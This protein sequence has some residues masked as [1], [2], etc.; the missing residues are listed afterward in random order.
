VAN[1][2]ERLGTRK[3][4]ETAGMGH[5]TLSLLSEPEAA[6]IYSIKIQGTGSIKVGN[7]IVVCDAGGG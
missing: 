4:A 5:H 2:G 6:A 3:A 7:R 1:A